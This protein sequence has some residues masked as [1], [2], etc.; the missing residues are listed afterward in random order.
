MHRYFDHLVL[1]L[2][3]L[4]KA[5]ETD[6]PVFGNTVFSRAKQYMYRVFI[7]YR[8][9]NVQQKRT[10]NRDEHSSHLQIA[11]YASQSL[12]SL[13]FGLIIPNYGYIRI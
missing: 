2:E 10:S 7:R 5:K 3:L 8:K 13:L 11:L 9:F 1:E 12:V 6:M 4:L